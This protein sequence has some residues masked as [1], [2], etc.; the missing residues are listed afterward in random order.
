VRSRI[1]VSDEDVRS[2]YQSHPGEFAGQDEVLVHHIFLPLSPA[3]PESEAAK[4]RARAE[5]VL[6][7]L[8]AGEPFAKVAREPGL[9]EDLLKALAAPETAQLG[10]ILA[11]YANLRDDIS[12]N[13]ADINGLAWNVTTNSKAEMSTPV[14]RSKP[15]TGKNRSALYRFLGLVSDTSGVTA[16]NKPDAIV[17]AELGGITIPSFGLKWKECE[18]FK[19]ENLSAFY[20]DAIANAVDTPSRRAEA[21]NRPSAMP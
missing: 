7:R 6:R 2:Y 21:K 8:R 12:Y 16:C 3:A 17:H 1:R 18:V 9:L 19:I 13:P 20:L 5:D 11:K 4:V 14:D 10:T 15:E